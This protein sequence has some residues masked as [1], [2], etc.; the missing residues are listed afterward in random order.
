MCVFGSALLY[1]ET[2]KT[3]E[4]L[5]EAFLECTNWNAPT[6]IFTDQ[7]AAIV[8]AVKTKFPRTFHGLCTFHI[9]H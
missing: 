8:A 2:T 9:L 7:C 5:F 1:D 3:F 4:W 6:T